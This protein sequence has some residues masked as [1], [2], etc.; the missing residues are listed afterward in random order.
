LKAAI[1]ASNTAP[2]T[3]GLEPQYYQQSNSWFLL[4]VPANFCITMNRMTTTTMTTPNQLPR[5]FNK[6]QTFAFPKSRTP[7]LP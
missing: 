7:N 5:N 1:I 6:L 2:P 4:D 3:L